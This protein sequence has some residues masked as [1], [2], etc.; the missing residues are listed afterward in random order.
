[1]MSAPSEHSQ[2]LVIFKLIERITPDLTE[3]NSKRDS[4]LN[5]IVVK[6]QQDLYTR[7]FDNLVKNSE[8]TNN[9]QKMLAENPNFL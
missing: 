3:F 6:K 8:I 1:Q 2:G 7:W 9:V 4:V 5:T